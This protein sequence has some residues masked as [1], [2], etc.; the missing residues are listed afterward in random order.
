M[1]ILEVNT[2]NKLLMHKG[3]SIRTPATFTITKKDIKKFKLLLHQAGVEE[4]SI[5]S[6]RKDDTE[7]VILPEQILP[8]LQEIQEEVKIEILDDEDETRS[9]LNQLVKDAKEES[10]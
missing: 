7:E 9:I 3:R 2:P 6:K 4:Y 8:L 10:E 1:Y 5:K